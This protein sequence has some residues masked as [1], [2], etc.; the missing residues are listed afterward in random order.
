MVNYKIDGDLNFNSEL[1]NSL[2]Q[3]EPD[4][5]EMCL[6]SSEKLVEPFVKLECGHSFNY[7]P[8][9][10]DIIN[11]KRLF[12]NMEV[13]GSSVKK[14]QIRCP[15]CRNIQNSLLPFIEK[16][17][18]EKIHGIN[19]FDEN[20][21]KY[22]YS[23]KGNC[24]YSSIN[25]YFNELSEENL[26]N[27]KYIF[28]SM[29]NVTKLK[30]N[31]NDYCGLHKLKVY[32]QILNENKKKLKQIEKENKMKLKQQQKEEK[33]KLK[34]M[35]HELCNVVLKTGPNKGLPCCKKVFENSKCKRHSIH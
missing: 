25:P 32:K 31:G 13:S 27:P 8:I 17:G 10:K 22:N 34:N 3:S 14:G 23:F 7:L 15:Y 33:E 35:V 12:N 1:L 2:N 18:V 24:C 21:Q 19:Y 28:C 26:D 4:N 9:Y 16:E 20:Y 30:E 5:D 6:I 11:H 29:I